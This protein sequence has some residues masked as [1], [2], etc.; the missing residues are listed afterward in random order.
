MVCLCLSDST[1]TTT[2]HIS[3]M[4]VCQTVCSQQPVQLLISSVAQ[5]GAYTKKLRRRQETLSNSTTRQ[6]CTTAPSLYTETLSSCFSFF[7]FIK[8]CDATGA[9]S[10]PVSSQAGL[11][12]SQP[13]RCPTHPTRNASGNRGASLTGS[14]CR[15]RMNRCALT[16][17][18]AQ[19][20]WRRS[21]CLRARACEPS[22]PHGQNPSHR[23]CTSP[24]CASPRWI[25]PGAPICQHPAPSQH[26]LAIADDVELSV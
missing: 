25:R 11:G 17:T 24:Q 3:Q 13:S 19:G 4:Q 18:S 1:A 10:V 23:T 26:I 22:I 2:R 14:C 20:C 16:R 12:R 21:P 9:G 7:L 6:S 5:L 15:K 8:V